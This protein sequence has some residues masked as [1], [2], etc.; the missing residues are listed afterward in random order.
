MSVTLFDDSTLSND[1]SDQHRNED[2]VDDQCIDSE[3]CVVM[4]IFAKER[5]GLPHFKAVGDVL[6]AHRVIVQRWRGKMQLLGK[7][8]MTSYVWGRK[9]AVHTSRG[10]DAA[11]EEWQRYAT[12]RKSLS[13]SDEDERYFK[14]LWHWGQSQLASKPLLHTVERFQIGDMCPS[15]RDDL[16]TKDAFPPFKQGDVIAMVV[17]IQPDRHRLSNSSTPVGY[18]R[19]W[20]GT[21]STASDP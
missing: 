20:D 7:P 8:N 3:R 19:L 15:E 10:G 6:R 14:E 13:F 12:A 17:A 5:S 11:T 9:T 1:G 21:G 16:T 18:L 4:N 2:D